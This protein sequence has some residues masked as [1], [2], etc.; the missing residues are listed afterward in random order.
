MTRHETFTTPHISDKD[1]VLATDLDG[2]FLGG[3]AD[4]RK[5][6]YNWIEANRDRVGL[7]NWKKRSPPH[8]MT[9]LPLCR[10]SCAARAG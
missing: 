8:G 6:F 3:S 2:T 10:Q 7:P 1:L 4:D 9:P 5:V